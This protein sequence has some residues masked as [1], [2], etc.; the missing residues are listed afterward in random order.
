MKQPLPPGVLPGKA[1]DLPSADELFNQT[2]ENK[3]GNYS[4][5]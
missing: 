1:D 4:L 3:R 5:K 2:I